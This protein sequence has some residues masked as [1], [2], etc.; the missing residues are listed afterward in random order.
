[1]ALHYL[2]RRQARERFAHALELMPELR[3]ERDSF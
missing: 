2:L 1:M 3:A